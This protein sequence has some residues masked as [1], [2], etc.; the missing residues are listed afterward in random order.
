MWWSGRV[1]LLVVQLGMT[2]AFL[3]YQIVG[4]A[5]RQDIWVLPL[6]GTREP[7]PLAR[8][9]SMEVTPRFAPDSRWIAYVSDETGKSE[10]YVQPFPPTGG[11]WQVSTGGG[12][13]PVWSGHELFY[14]RPGGM[15]VA[16]DVRAAPGDGGRPAAFTVGP[17]K[18]LFQVGASATAQSRYDVAP[19]RQRFLVRVSSRPA[20]QPIAVVLN[21][22]ASLRR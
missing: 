21:W 14:I 6:G 22:P 12:T 11:K 5:S 20:T 3:A 16:V 18:A 13:E 8:T 19:D 1:D 9:A 10:V 4:D 15:L 7:I 2:V 17:P